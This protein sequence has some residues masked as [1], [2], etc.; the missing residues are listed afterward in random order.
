MKDRGIGSPVGPQRGGEYFWGGGTS[1]MPR[2]R[3]RP[4]AACRMR[5]GRRRP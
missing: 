3:T 1:G 2:P 5:Y 4:G